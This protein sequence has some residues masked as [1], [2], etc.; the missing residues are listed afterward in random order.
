MAKTDID[1][2][3]RVNNTLP[4]SKYR[5]KDVPPTLHD[6]HSASTDS[7]KFGKACIQGQ[8]DHA[9]V[10]LNCF[11]ATFDLH[12]SSHPSLWR[13]G[14]ALNPLASH[15]QVSKQLMPV[16]S[17]VL[18]NPSFLL[19][20]D[21][22]L[23]PRLKILLALHGVDFPAQASRGQ[24][25]QRYDELVQNL[26]Q[27]T[28][29]R[30]ITVNVNI[31]P[32]PQA[33]KQKPNCQTTSKTRPPK[34]LHLVH[35]ARS[36]HV[37]KTRQPKSAARNWAFFSPY[38]WQS[39]QYAQALSAGHS[40]SH[41]TGSSARCGHSSSQPR[42]SAGRRRSL[43]QASQLSVGHSLSQVSESSNGYSL[44]RSAW[45]ASQDSKQ[46]PR[47]SK[48]QTQ[49]HG[50]YT[51]GNPLPSSSDFW[52]PRSS[53]GRRHSLSQASQLSAGRSLSQVSES[54]D[55]HSL[56]RSARLA[57]Q[58]SKQAASPSE[59]QTQDHGPYTQGNPLPSSSDFREPDSQSSS[60]TKSSDP[61]TESSHPDTESS[62]KTNPTHSPD[63]K[64]S[65]ASLLDLSSEL[66][67]GADHGASSSS[68][69]DPS[70]SDNHPDSPHTSSQAA[71]SPPSSQTAPISSSDRADP[72][73][74]R[75]PAASSPASS[76]ADSSLPQ[77]A[78]RAP[79]SQVE[80]KASSQVESNAS[81]RSVGSNKRRR[82]TAKQT[83]PEA[84]F[85]SCDPLQA[86]PQTITQAPSGFTKQ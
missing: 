18:P 17:R 12:G 5:L 85:G 26:N 21:K 11:S 9:N 60:D 45:L 10:V 59:T 54:S 81:P 39:R 43:S 70:H 34:P 52:E 20:A 79:S 27:A 42:S 82:P 78:S 57:S 64:S 16:R 53:A 8:W 84:P 2:P 58:D 23:V 19:G 32:H 51:Q 4:F 3:P 28:P 35:E 22:F 36:G 76:P 68:Q 50:P 63:P 56:R 15:Y 31:P 71:P 49:D 61:D 14:P 77:A 29:G 7:K 46:A 6:S 72:I 41:M 48:T 65:K 75:N 25:V 44:Q 33:K 62:A 13:V 55:G 66:N 38:D 1:L 40:T 73:P 67:V 47:A 30:P 24:L 86:P 69:N 83:P 74:P 80:S 37:G